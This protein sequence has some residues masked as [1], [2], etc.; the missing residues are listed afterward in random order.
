EDNPRSVDGL[1]YD[2]NGVERVF[3]FLK[4]KKGSSGEG[5]V[6]VDKTVYGGRKQ[7]S[8]LM[9][10]LKGI[11]NPYLNVNFDILLLTKVFG[12]QSVKTNIISNIILSELKLQ[13][14]GVS[15]TKEVRSAEIPKM[16]AQGHKWL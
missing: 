16:Y 3:F 8:S 14:N 5:R 11:A 12:I 13:D 6:V 1:G 2:R 9:S 7:P 10:M 4:K 15:F